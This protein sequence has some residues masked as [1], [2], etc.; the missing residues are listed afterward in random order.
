MGRAIGLP[1]RSCHPGGLRGTVEAHH[2]RNDACGGRHAYRLF[3]ENDRVAEILVGGDPDEDATVRRGDPVTLPLV[4]R[5]LA[6]LDRRWQDRRAGCPYVFHRDGWRVRR[7]ETAWDAAATAIG[8]GRAGDRGKRP[9]TFHDL[10]RSSARIL[11]RA[12]VD[13]V[14]IMARA[15]WKTSAMFER[16]G[17]TDQRDQVDAQHA[18]DAAFTSTTVAPLP[19]TAASD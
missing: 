17:I 6:V 16:Y 4:G 5:L 10:R 9:F 13:Q 14:T 19:R 12:G 8:R 15:G 11:R 7:Y 2:L 18:M 3:F 1:R